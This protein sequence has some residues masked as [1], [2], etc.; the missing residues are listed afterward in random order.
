[1]TTKKTSAKKTTAKKI[2]KFSKKTESFLGAEI[3]GDFYNT[4]ITAK[5]KNLI[6]KMN[7]QREILN[8]KK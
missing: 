1:M 3:S 4:E 7:K 8:K 6:K 5:E 2:K